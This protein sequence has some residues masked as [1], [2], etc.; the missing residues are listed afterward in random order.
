MQSVSMF[1]RLH[2]FAASQLKFYSIACY[3]YIRAPIEKPNIFILYPRKVE[4]V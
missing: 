2:F 3:E 1:F 4:S